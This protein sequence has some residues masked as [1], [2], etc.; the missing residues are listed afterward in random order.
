MENETEVT[1]QIKTVIF[2]E[3]LKELLIQ[4]VYNNGVPQIWVIAGFI[5]EGGKSFDIRH[6]YGSIVIVRIS[7]P[8]VLL[9]SQYL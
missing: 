3:K 6:Q 9:A 1:L 2:L 4:K 7:L 5:T 8:G